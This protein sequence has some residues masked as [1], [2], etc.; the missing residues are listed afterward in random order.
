MRIMEYRSRSLSSTPATDGRVVHLLRPVGRFA[1]HLAEMCMA[2]CAGA[3]ALSLLFFGAANLLGYDDLTRTAPALSVFVIALN[4]SVPMAA[5]MRYRGMDWEPTLEMAGSTMVVGIAL[6]VAYWL[7]LVAR[8]S[9]VE[10][11]TSLACPVMFAVMLARF[12][13]YSTSHSA[14]SAHH[15]PAG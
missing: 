12:R 6:I 8:D 2:M 11:Q 14:H 15:V 4:L 9:L 13:L 10:I 1:A 3:I 5:W 7:D